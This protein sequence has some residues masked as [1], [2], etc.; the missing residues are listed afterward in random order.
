M[1]FN[2]NTLNISATD[3]NRENFDCPSSGV[4]DKHYKIKILGKNSEAIADS[5]VYN[6]MNL[7]VYAEKV[8]NQ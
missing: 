7:N 1:D 5:G 4:C 6:F 3:S 2:A 8:P